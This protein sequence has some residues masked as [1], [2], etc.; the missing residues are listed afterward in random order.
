M[1]I[2]FG[3]QNNFRVLCI[4][5][6]RPITGLEIGFEALSDVRR[7]PETTGQDQVRLR[8]MSVRVLFPVTVTADVRSAFAAPSFASCRTAH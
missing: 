7:A 8:L 4:G 6:V 5:S 2:R 1:S 3:N